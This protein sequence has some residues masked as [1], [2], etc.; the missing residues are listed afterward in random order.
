MS[1]EA[2]YFDTALFHQA[3]DG[4]CQVYY[5]VENPPA[6]GG[7]HIRTF[8]WGR[9]KWS[10]VNI[11]TGVSSGTFISEFGIMGVPYFYA[12]YPPEGTT[13]SVQVKPPLAPQAP[14]GY[15]NVRIGVFYDGAVILDEM[16]GASAVAVYDPSWG[17]QVPL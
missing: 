5:T 16:T 15:K 7:P 17:E 13:V 4:A 6:T 12:A 1:T 2:P 9:A 10:K 3:L 11:Q 8:A 14:P